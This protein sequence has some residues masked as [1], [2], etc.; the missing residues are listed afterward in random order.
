M[1]Q[2]FIELRRKNYE[3]IERHLSPFN[4]LEWGKLSPHSVPLCYPLRCNNPVS[5]QRLIENNVFIANYWPDLELH[6]LTEFECILTNEIIYVPLNNIANDD[7]CLEM[8]EI[9]KEVINS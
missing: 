6:K 2:K 7:E 5:K 3:T 1:N 4:K 9:I 8:C